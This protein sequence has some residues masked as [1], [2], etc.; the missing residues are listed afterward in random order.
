MG[1]MSYSVP[2]LHSGE[3][4]VLIVSFSHLNIFSEI[5]THIKLFKYRLQ[6]LRKTLI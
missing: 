2:I 6:I 3:A 5:L 1:G 4:F